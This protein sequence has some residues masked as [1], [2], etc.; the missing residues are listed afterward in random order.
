MRLPADS[1]APLSFT[2]DERKAGQP[3]YRSTV[4]VDRSTGT[5]ASV[6]RF[7]DQNLGRRTRSWLRYIHTGEYYGVAGQT[8]AGI[9]SFAGVMLVWTGFA[10]SLHRL[11]GWIKRRKRSPEMPAIETPVQVHEET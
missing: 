9:A 4:T 5:I 2:I 11:S 10:L 7:Q 3:Q 8:I 1:K 6:E